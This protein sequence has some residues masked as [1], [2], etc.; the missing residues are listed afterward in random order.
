MCRGKSGRR[1]SI[2]GGGPS[3]FAWFASKA[4]ADAAA[5]AMRQGFL[6]AGFDACVY[7]SPVAGPRA[8]IME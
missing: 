1:A 8:E 5:P 2:S 4:D 6:D 7:V 3:V